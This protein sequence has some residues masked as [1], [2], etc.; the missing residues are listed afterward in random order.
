MLK[1]NTITNNNI[2]LTITAIFIYLS[3]NVDLKTGFLII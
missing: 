3:I 1:I 2:K